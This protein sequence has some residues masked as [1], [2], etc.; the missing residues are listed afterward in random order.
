MRE[1]AD[2]FRPAIFEK[3]AEPVD[4]GPV[5]AAHIKDS[6]RQRGLGDAPNIGAGGSYCQYPQV[7]AHFSDERGLL[8]LYR[9]DGVE[10]VEYAGLFAARYLQGE[11]HSARGKILDSLVL[12]VVGIENARDAGGEIVDGGVKPDEFDND[13]FKT[14]SLG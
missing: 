8:F 5:I 7:R 4:I 9:D 13:S 6:P 1:S 11:T 12:N 3:T 2:D 10:P 14:A